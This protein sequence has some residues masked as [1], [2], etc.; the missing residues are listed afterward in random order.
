MNPGREGNGR[1]GKAGTPAVRNN[2][3]VVR[4]VSWSD[5]PASTISELVGLVTKYGAAI[6]FGCTSDGGAYSL[7]ILDNQNKVKEYPRDEQDVHNILTWLR[8]EYFGDGGKPA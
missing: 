7:C 4:S 3:R 8:D 1:K 2:L 6:M 5:I